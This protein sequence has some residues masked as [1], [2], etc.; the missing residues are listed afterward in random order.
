[1]NVD[2]SPRHENSQADPLRE[3]VRSHPVAAFLVLVFAI[4]GVLEVVPMPEGLH[5]PLENILGALVPAFAVVAVVGG[6]PG[7]RDL[8]RRS[9]RWRVPLR[10]Y[11]LAL[12]ALPA[13][14]VIVAPAPYGTAPLEALRDNWPLLFTSFL[15]T[16]AFM[17]VFDN[18]AEEVGWTGFLFASLEQRHRP[19]VAAVLAFVP[20]WAWHALSFVHDTGSWPDGLL[21]AG[22]VALPLLA[23]RVMTG[24]LYNATGASVLIAGLFHATFNATVNPTGLAVAVLDL[25]QDE[26][27]VVVGALVVVAAAVVTVATHG[28]LGRRGGGDRP[29][30]G[31][32]VRTPRGRQR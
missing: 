30:S 9:L 27:V 8:A 15:P 31:G 10:W 24:W 32:P 26:V 16:L 12:L 20:F 13:A 22:I 2:M 23:S 7:V 5:G 18:V 17:A 21:L 25:P 1:M 29:A 19:L 11:A 14:T 28:R 4:T 3:S 6:R